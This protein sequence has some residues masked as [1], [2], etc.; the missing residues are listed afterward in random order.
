MRSGFGDGVAAL[1]TL[2]T[3]IE[4]FARCEAD[5]IESEGDE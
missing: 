5:G 2:T 1:L 3:L 4:G